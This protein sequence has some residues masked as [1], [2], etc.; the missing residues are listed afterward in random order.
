[1]TACLELK[2]DLSTWAFSEDSNEEALIRQMARTAGV[3]RAQ[4]VYASELTR[5]HSPPSN[6]RACIDIHLTVSRLASFRLASPRL[7]KPDLAC[8][9]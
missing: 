9:A 6:I 4:L 3:A 7:A 2:L 5:A 8:P 1:M